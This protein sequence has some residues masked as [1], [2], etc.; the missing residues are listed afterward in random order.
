MVEIII[1]IILAIA[2]LAG[3]WYGLRQSAASSVDKDAAVATTKLAKERVSELEQLQLQQ[4]AAK[5]KEENDQVK[6]ITATSAADRLRDAFHNG[7]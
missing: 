7:R 2:G 6:D 5:R 4:E 1:G 3:L